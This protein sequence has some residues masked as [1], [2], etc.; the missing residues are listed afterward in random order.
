M[1]NATQPFDK[2]YVRLHR[3]QS[4]VVQ[5]CEQVLLYLS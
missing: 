1:K 2:S 4:P 3:L 5:L